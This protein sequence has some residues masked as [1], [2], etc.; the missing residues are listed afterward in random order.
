[1]GLSSKQPW[2]GTRNDPTE[3]TQLRPWH[4]LPPPTTPRAGGM[5]EINGSLASGL[6]FP[7][8]IGSNPIQC[9][10]WENRCYPLLHGEPGSMKSL[11]ASARS[12]SWLVALAGMCKHPAQQRVS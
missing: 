3:Q 8:E 10:Y 9:C 1:M 12:P 6:A 7:V 2:R 4:P 5:E 11:V